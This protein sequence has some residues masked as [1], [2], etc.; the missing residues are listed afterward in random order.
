MKELRALLVNAKAAAR[1]VQRARYYDAMHPENLSDLTR[2]VLEHRDQRHWKQF[3][4]PKEL[5]ISLCVE[6]AE[7]LGLMQW[8][9][10]PQLEQAVEQ[11]R[12][13]IADELAD[14]LHSVLLLASELNISP[15]EALVSKLADDAKKYP[16]AKARG[17]NLKYD[18]L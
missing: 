5:A 4:T 3:H 15:G 2:L 1:R 8:K 7:L 9:N 11:K 16:V 13:E 10:G 6:S 18:E 12:Q 14:V 17:K